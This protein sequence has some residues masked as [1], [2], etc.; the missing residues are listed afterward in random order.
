M[1][2]LILAA[3]GAGILLGAPGSPAFAGSINLGAASGYAVLGLTGSSDQLSSGPLM[4]NGNVGVASGAS[5]AMSSGTVTGL[6]ET[7]SLGNVNLSGGTTFVGGGACSSAA[8]C[9][10]VSVVPGALASAQS[11]AT[12]LASTAATAAMS[13]TQSFA[14]ITGPQTI[15]G[16]GGMNVIDGPETR[17]F[18]SPEAR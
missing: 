14:S 9:A 1:R 5:L 2:N 3:I 17:G 11:A 13:P 4:I 8:T 10:G 6:I 12:A 7:S 15:T 16:N 18:T